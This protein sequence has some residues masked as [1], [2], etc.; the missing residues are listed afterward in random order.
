MSLSG[1]LFHMPP[2][3]ACHAVAR[4]ASRFLYHGRILCRAFLALSQCA[5]IL[6]YRPHLRGNAAP[7]FEQS[8]FSAHVILME[9]TLFG[10]AE[11]GRES[12]S[13]D[14]LLMIFHDAAYFCA[15]PRLRARA[16]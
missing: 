15:S 2:K 9:A 6:F 14:A 13:S 4:D 5:M 11:L 12:G 8:D 16:I 1:A 7:S 3:I 10:L